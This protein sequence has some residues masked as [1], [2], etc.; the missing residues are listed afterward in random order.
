MTEEICVVCGNE[1]GR[2]TWTI[3]DDTYCDECGKTHLNEE[4]KKAYARNKKEA[5]ERATDMAKK[6]ERNIYVIEACPDRPL[7]TIFKTFAFLF[8]PRDAF[9]GIGFTPEGEQFEFERR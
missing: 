5:Y 3:G 9:G 6:L 7:P 4:T 2:S 1:T 8:E